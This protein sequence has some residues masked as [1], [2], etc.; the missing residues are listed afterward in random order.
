[1]KKNTRIKATSL[2]SRAEFDAAVDQLARTTV[3]LRKLEA[4]RDE[5]LQTVRAKY[6]GP[7]ADRGA[8]IEGLA[9][10]IEKYAEEHRDE[11]FTGKVKSAETA[12]ALFGFRLGQPTLKTL[13]KAWTWDRV[14]EQ[15]DALKLD[16]FIR[17]KRECD[18]EAMKAH[19]DAAALA[20]VGCRI[21]QAE[22]FFVEPKEQAS[23]ERSAA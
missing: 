17:T 5:Q 1:M 21:D 14:L 2:K 16:R 22:T 10:V 9:L 19:L 11:L 8:A 15:L 7:C 3:E 20:T 23:D 4:A 12:L 13:S 6:D 18:K